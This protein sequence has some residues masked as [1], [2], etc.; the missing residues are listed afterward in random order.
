MPAPY[1]LHI[2][3]TQ[4]QTVEDIL[5]RTQGILVLIEQACGGPGRIANEI[6]LLCMLAARDLDLVVTCL[7]GDAPT[8]QFEGQPVRHLT[9]LPDRGN[10]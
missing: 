1:P 4:T 10:R 7:S 2:E 6:G 9:G 5:T 8:D 3:V